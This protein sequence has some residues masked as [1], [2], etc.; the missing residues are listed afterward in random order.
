MDR[1]WVALLLALCSLASRAAVTSYDWT[2]DW[3]TGP[4]ASGTLTFDDLSDPAP[5]GI[6]WGNVAA[7]LPAFIDGLPDGF[8][9]TGSVSFVGGSVIEV[10]G[11]N[12]FINFCA[13]GAIVATGYTRAVFTLSGRGSAERATYSFEGDPRGTPCSA[14]S[15]AAVLPPECFSFETGT[16]TFTQVTPATPIPEPATL[17]LLLAGLAG[18]GLFTRHRRR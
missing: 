6:V 8:A 10:R 4:D 1:F 12:D 15:A 11:C 18:M 16:T 17:V 2:I 13:D 7:P 3:P 5:R 9:A 14:S